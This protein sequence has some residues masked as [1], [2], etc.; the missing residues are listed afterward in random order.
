MKIRNLLFN[1]IFNT[2]RPKLHKNFHVWTSLL[3]YLEMKGFL[4]FKRDFEK[5]MEPLCIITINSC[6]T[7]KSKVANVT[8][9]CKLI[10]NWLNS[11]QYY[12]TSKTINFVL[13]KSWETQLAK[14]EP[15]RMTSKKFV[16]SIQTCRPVQCQFSYKVSACR[17]VN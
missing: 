16:I 5:T 14:I 10:I 11:N 1:F 7:C 4:Y 8:L 17:I 12:F 6:M 9:E 13:L 15:Y 2:M 3:I